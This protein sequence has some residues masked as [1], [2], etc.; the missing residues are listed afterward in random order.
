MW[1]K[2]GMDNDSYYMIAQ[3]RDILANG[4]PKENNFTF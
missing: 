2:A 3:G 1:V 4:I